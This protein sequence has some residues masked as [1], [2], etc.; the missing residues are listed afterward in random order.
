M[1]LLE[2]E[3]AYDN[4][5]IHHKDIYMHENIYMCVCVCVWMC[6]CACVCVC[7]SDLQ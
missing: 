5:T 7:E 2:I 4:V 3:L 6:V 1:L